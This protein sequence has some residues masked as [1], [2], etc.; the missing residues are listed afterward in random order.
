MGDYITD[1]WCELIRLVSSDKSERFT[2]NIRS[3]I[4][5][6]LL[7]LIISNKIQEFPYNFNAEF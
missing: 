6:F 5:M 1:Y 4:Y 2:T 7:S 3:K